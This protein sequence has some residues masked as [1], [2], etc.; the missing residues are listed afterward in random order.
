MGRILSKTL[1]SSRQFLCKKLRLHITN[2][3]K[4]VTF[5]RNDLVVKIGINYTFNAFELG[6]FTLF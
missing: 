5:C 1:K 2:N 3:L 4:T 6:V